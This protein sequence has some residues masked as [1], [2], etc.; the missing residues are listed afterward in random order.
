M[1]RSQ[2]L[3]YL[4]IHSQNTAFWRRSTTGEWSA[5]C[6]TP[7]VLEALSEDEVAERIAQMERSDR[8]SDM[9]AAE[10]LG[11]PT[12]LSTT[13]AGTCEICGDDLTE[14]SHIYLVWDVTQREWLTLC[15]RHQPDTYSLEWRGDEKR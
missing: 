15:D 9:T 7:A 10:L 4:A 6:P 13:L 1:D 3:A 14:D 11:G 2:R 5:W 12:D 8:V